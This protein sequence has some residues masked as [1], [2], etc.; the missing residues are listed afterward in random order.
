[1]TSEARD[2]SIDQ[3]QPLKLYTFTR[4]SKKWRYTDADRI[5]FY[6]GN[7]YAP[8][9]I[10][11]TQITD[12][13][14]QNK[15]SITLTL[16]KSLTVCDNWRPYPPADPINVTIYTQHFGETD[17]LADWVGRI[18]SP[19]FGDT[20]LA[21]TSEPSSTMAQ[22]AGGGRTWQR[23]CDLLLYSQGLGLCNVDPELHKITGTLTGAASLMLSAVEFATLPSGR[24][25][26]GYIEWTREDGLLDRRSID[27][28]SGSTIM[29][30]YGGPELLPGLAFNAFPGCN[31]S[32]DDCTYYENNDNYGGELWI[33]GRDY[34][35]GNPI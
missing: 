6:G 21:L 32:W 28:H 14:E 12:G 23:G 8:A 27:T 33:P 9:P 15:I 3:G 4:A 18:I 16:P 25:A 5:I 1:M 31:Q 26:G 29:V 34:Y 11:H 7:A 24:L 20:T 17:F 19:K 22:R 10:T 35:D 30:D 2:A 13:G